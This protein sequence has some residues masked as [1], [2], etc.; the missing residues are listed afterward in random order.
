M[1]L[2][3]MLEDPL[4]ATQRI[5]PWVVSTHIKDGAVLLNEEA[6]ITFPAEIGAGVIDLQKICHLLA[7]LPEK[8]HFSIEDHGG[9]FNLPVF[10]PL[11]LSKFPDLMTEEFTRIVRMSLETKKRIKRGELAI[12]NREDWT[13]ICESRVKRDIRTLRQLLHK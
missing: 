13:Q 7:L 2:L 12:T 6:L 10:D 9:S 1:N 4:T 3:T 11:F 5:L 8:L